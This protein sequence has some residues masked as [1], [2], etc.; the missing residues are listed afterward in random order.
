M[1]KVIYLWIVLL[2]VCVACKKNQ[3]QLSGKFENTSKRCLLL[4][5]IEPDDIV[6]VDT[7]LLLNGNFSHSITEE[8]IGIYLLKYNDTTFLS[9]IAQSGDCL[10][11][12]GDAQNLKRTYNIQGNEESRLLLE[13]DR[14]LNLFYDKTKEWTVIFLQHKYKDDYE[15]TMA[16]LDSLYNQEF[17]RHKEYL[18]Q[19]IT[20]HAG[21]LATLPAFYQ[22]A[23]NIAFFDS[24]KDRALLQEI[25]NALSKT[26]PN[27]IY[28]EDLKERLEE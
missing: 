8:R 26:Y 3:V 11:F 17:E 2:V 5:K 21:R 20:Q 18:T 15:E 28:V 12:S 23:G 9:F 14:K 24:Q 19:F 25:Y 1:W 4:S 7:I 13:T 6:F 22:K 10:V 16:Y 27:S